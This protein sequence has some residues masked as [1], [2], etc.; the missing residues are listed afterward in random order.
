MTGFSHLY[1]LLV[2]IKSLSPQLLPSLSKDQ[3]DEGNNF[4]VTALVHSSGLLACDV[5]VVK[6]FLIVAYYCIKEGFLLLYDCCFGGRSFARTRMS[7]R[8]FSFLNATIG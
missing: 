2:L 8:E 5:A 4:I 3:L 6:T 7:L 1:N